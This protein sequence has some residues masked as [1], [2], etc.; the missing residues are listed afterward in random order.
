MK[1]KLLSTSL[2]IAALAA[3]ATAS[4]ITADALY[5]APDL[6]LALPDDDP[7]GVSATISIPDSFT[8]VKIAIAVRMDHTWVGDLI[9]TLTGPDGTTITLADRP[10]TDDPSVD[11][12]D[13]SNLSVD[14]PLYFGDL[15]P[16]PA[17]MMGGLHC[18]GTD[19]VIGSDCTRWYAPDQSL[20]DAFVGTSAF[21]DWTLT[22]S[23]NEGL[24]VGTL[25]SWILAFN[26]QAVP[27]PAAVWLFASGLFAL[28]ARRRRQ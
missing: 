8:I 6:G 12:G 11:A 24:D 5:G 21:G 23:D 27:V 17:E 2:A 20:T 22:V 1:R 26:Y 18:T 16:V 4:A 15:S 3:S 9:F 13:S 28:V 25:D 19:S 14:H 7:N 10:G